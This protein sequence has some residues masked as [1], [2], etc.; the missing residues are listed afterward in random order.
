MNLGDTLSTCGDSVL[1]DAGAGYNYYSWST[2]E[3]TQ[4]I[5]A[6]ATGDYA[7]TVGDSV[8]VNN[9]YSISFD[10]VDDY[11]NVG[12][13]SY[14]NPSLDFTWEGYFMLTDT[15]QNYEFFNQNT[16]YN[17]QAQINGL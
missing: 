14:F 7:A 1:L 3:S 10:G 16:Y 2:G 9:N 13:S 5:Y 6:S 17:E 12:N 8:G 11:L 4:T 15:N